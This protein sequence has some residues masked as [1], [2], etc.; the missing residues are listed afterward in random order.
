MRVR[1]SVSTTS[2]RGTALSGKCNGVDSGVGRARAA[3]VASLAAGWLDTQQQTHLALL[4]YA[5]F[6]VNAAQ[7]ILK[8]RAARLAGPSLVAPA[9][10]G[11]AA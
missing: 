10:L 5:T 11:R 2:Y 9:T 4:A 7:F 3:Y 8:L 1:A 6:T